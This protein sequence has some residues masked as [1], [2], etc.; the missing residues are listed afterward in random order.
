MTANATEGATSAVASDADDDDDG[1]ITQPSL[2]RI[3]ARLAAQTAAASAASAASAATPQADDAIGAPGDM[4]AHAP[5]DTYAGAEPVHHA[6]PELP[7][8]TLAERQ[9]RMQRNG[10]VSPMARDAI[11]GPII[12]ALPIAP[13]NGPVTGPMGPQRSRPIGST[14]RQT[15]QPLTF[16]M[17]AALTPVWITPTPDANGRQGDEDTALAYESP[18]ASAPEPTADH[19]NDNGQA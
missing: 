13:V 2:R 15:S 14:R 10:T 4:P 6:E 3:A 12:D 19:T 16:E 17:A 18:L 8:P 5:D 9:A 1:A 11:L 7:D